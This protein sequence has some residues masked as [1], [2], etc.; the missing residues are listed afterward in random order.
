MNHENP[1]VPAPPAPLTF[2]AV[3]GIGFAAERERF[4]PST[5]SLAADELGP[6]FELGLLA[7]SRLVRWPGRASW[8]SMNGLS[9]LMDALEQRKDRWI[10]PATRGTAL[11]RTSAA[12]SSDDQHWVEFCYAMQRAADAAG[13][14][15]SPA[16]QLVGAIGEMQDNIYQH[17]G[18]PETGLVAFRATPGVLEW[19]VCDSGIGVLRSLTSCSEFAHVV[20][21]GE[22]LK[23]TLSDGVSRHGRA[24]GRGLGYQPLFTGLANLRGSLRFR[25]GNYALTI[26]G[27]NPG[28]LP[29][30]LAQKARLSGFLISVRCRC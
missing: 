14:A 8:L 12:P 29:S 26:E 30:K 13:F 5:L 6:L 17:S 9:P 1:I 24:S 23:L 2:D 25:S 16:A 4:N 21:D 27:V 20:D 10:C 3:D 19:V 15:S 28:T 7:K 22:A 18:A 11:F